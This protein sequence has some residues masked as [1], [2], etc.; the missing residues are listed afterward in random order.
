MFM[1]ANEFMIGALKINLFFLNPINFLIL[2]T[3]LKAFCPIAWSILFKYS[4][5][6][7]FL[8]IWKWYKLDKQQKRSCSCKEG[9]LPCLTG[10]SLNTVMSDL[11][12]SLTKRRSLIACVLTL[13]EPKVKVKLFTLVKRK[14]W[15][16]GNDIFSVRSKLLPCIKTYTI[17]S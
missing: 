15:L 1:Y 11:T 3:F 6:C 16:S 10:F 8:S 12:L 17:T 4:V 13:I 9:N 5:T 14:S 7:F 2:M